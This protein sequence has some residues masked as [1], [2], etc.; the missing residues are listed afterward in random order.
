MQIYYQRIETLPDYVAWVRCNP[1]DRS[2]V[3]EMFPK[4]KYELL[5][6][7]QPNYDPI[8][9]SQQV[10]YNPP[11]PAWGLDVWK[12]EDDGRYTELSTRENPQR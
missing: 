3:E 2:Q 6:A 8:T 12:K 4:D 7:V 5:I 10:L 11:A 9:C 1:E